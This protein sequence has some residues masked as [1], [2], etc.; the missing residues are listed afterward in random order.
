[1]KT[2]ALDNSVIFGTSEAFFGPV[3]HED[4][5]LMV[6][7]VNVGLLNYDYEGRRDH[8]ID[9]CLFVSLNTMQFRCDNDITT[10]GGATGDGFIVLGGEPMEASPPWYEADFYSTDAFLVLFSDS[11]FSDTPFEFKEEQLTELFDP[12]N[13]G[14]GKIDKVV[15]DTGEFE[16]AARVLNEY[17]RGVGADDS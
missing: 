5:V 17:W 13:W 11:R 3:F 8:W 6:P 1:M 10:V 14:K 12:Q 15:S 9:K 7:Y 4:K 16:D 2:I